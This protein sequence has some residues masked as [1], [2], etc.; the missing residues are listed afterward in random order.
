M[1]RSPANTN[2][3]QKNSQAFTD[4]CDVTAQLFK[5]E[6]R[7]ASPAPPSVWTRYIDSRLK[8]FGTR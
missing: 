8:Q 5:R 6:K 7:S 4:F 1:K 3:T 2:A